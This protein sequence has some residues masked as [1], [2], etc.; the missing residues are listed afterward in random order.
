MVKEAEGQG[1]P[2]MVGALKRGEIWDDLYVLKPEQDQFKVK[3][4][5]TKSDGFWLR[6]QDEAYAFCVDLNFLHSDAFNFT[7]LPEFSETM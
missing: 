2:M 3:L 1:E 4:L 5:T 6:D 7:N